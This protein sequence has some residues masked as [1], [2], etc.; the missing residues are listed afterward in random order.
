M[1]TQIK[2]P[3]TL[4]DIHEIHQQLK[5]RN[6]PNTKISIGERKVFREILKESYD[7]YKDEM[8]EI[9]QEDIQHFNS[10][11]NE[12]SSLVIGERKASTFGKK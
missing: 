7:R 12:N 1:T 2:K 5:V 6:N 11:M 9:I 4:E 10:M 3:L 8:N